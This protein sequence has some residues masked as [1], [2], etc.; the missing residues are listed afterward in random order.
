MTAPLVHFVALVGRF[1]EAGARDAFESLVAQLVILDH[2]DARQVA[3]R[4]G[5]GGLDVIVGCPTGDLDVW[6]AKFFYPAFTRDHRSKV[7]AALEAAQRTAQDGGGRLRRWTLCV[8]VNLDVAGS[9]WWDSLVSAHPDIDIRLWGLTGLEA[10]LTSSAGRDIRWAYFELMDPTS[11]FRVSPPTTVD[12]ADPLDLGVTR[13]AGFAY[14][15]LYVPRD[16]DRA[17]GEAVASRSFVL[18]DGDA[19]AGKNRTLARV[20]AWRLHRFVQDRTQ[21]LIF[22]RAMLD[23]GWMGE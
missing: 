10:R 16:V 5:D 9:R 19:A 13:A 2:H 11:G 18:I 22:D 17:I 23:R 20:A 12:D 14:T 1:G 15:P 3:V 4:R 7:K 21:E 6:Q 8:P